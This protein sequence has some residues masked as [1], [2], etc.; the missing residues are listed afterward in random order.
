MFY[1]PLLAGDPTNGT[2]DPLSDVMRDDD[3][4][5]VEIG[6]SPEVL[7]IDRPPR[8]GSHAPAPNLQAKAI[9]QGHPVQNASLALSQPARQVRTRDLRRADQPVQGSIL[10]QSVSAAEEGKKVK[11]AANQARLLQERAIKSGK[12]AG[13]EHAR[14]AKIMNEAQNIAAQAMNA[15]CAEKQRLMAKAQKTAAKAQLHDARA[16]R[17]EADA[18]QF[19]ASAAELA[20]R[21]R[22]GAVALKTYWSR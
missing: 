6:N 10:P 20:Q 3:T 19:R 5:R 16:K 22:T 9:P 21:A 2:I 11:V 1:G 15:C 13:A 14:V 17:H 12:Q 7:R 4:I 8:R 18:H